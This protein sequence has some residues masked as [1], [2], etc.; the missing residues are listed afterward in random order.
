MSH[1]RRNR[2]VLLNR[3]PESDPFRGWPFVPI[4]WRN[5]LA[6]QD[7]DSAQMSRDEDLGAWS[8]PVDISVND[9]RYALSI[10]LPGTKREDVNVAFH[11][12]ILTVKG[13]KKPH[14]VVDGDKQHRAERLYGAFERSFRLP[15]DA[16][17]D[18][19]RAS[20]RDGVLSI[21]IPR[22]KPSEPQHV[23]IEA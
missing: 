15:A 5:D 13:E 2:R 19:M 10:E 21:E 14:E 6:A 8:P 7:A 20:Y 17:E 22:I 12:K 23:E 9:D 18:E 16:E 4:Q 3:L 11:E 1:N